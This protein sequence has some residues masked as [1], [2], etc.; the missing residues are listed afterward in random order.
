MRWVLII[1]LAT[2][3]VA[4]VATGVWHST[5]LARMQ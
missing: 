4:Y 5:A 1:L 2:L 3:E